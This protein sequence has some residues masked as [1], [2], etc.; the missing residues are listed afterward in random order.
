MDKKE[1]NKLGPLLKRMAEL[2]AE[3]DS[4]SHQIDQH[5]SH[6]ASTTWDGEDQAEESEETATG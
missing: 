2:N 4:L 1:E 3:A 5:L 6:R